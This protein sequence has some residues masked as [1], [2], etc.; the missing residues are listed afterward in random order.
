MVAD[1]RYGWNSNTR[2]ESNHTICDIDTTSKLCSK[3]L[4]RV[5]LVRAET[6]MILAPLDSGKWEESSVRAPQARTPKSYT[7]TVVDMV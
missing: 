5:C 6:T 1:N 3:I 2:A 4:S 7:D